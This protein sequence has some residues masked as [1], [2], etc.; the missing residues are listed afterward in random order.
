VLAELGAPKG[1][2]VV[3]AAVFEVGAGAVDFA[4]VEAHANFVVV[5][6]RKALDS[7]TQD[8]VGSDATNSE[9]PIHGLR[10]SAHRCRNLTAILDRASLVIAFG[11]DS[12]PVVGA[13]LVIFAAG[14]G[15]LG[16]A[17]FGVG[18]SLRRGLGEEVGEGFLGHGL[19]GEGS[20][21]ALAFQ[22]ESGAIGVEAA[23]VQG[24]RGGE[25]AF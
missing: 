1:G 5:T 2:A 6:V 9:S 20:V 11:L 4:I 19:Q 7:T 16:H 25:S 8:A 17:T 10:R 15:E 24:A 3:G 12:V 14:A 23:L 18:L 22:I 13:L 21:A